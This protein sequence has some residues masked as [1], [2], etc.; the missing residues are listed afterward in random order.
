MSSLFELTYGFDFAALYVAN[1]GVAKPG[2]ELFR[3]KGYGWVRLRLF[4]SPDRLPNDLAYNW[5][6]AECPEGDG[7]FP[8]TPAGQRRF[9]EEVTRLVRATP[10]GRGKGVFR[11]K[12]AV[13]PGPIYSRGLFNDEGE[14]L[15]A[16][17]VF[18]HPSVT[19]R[20]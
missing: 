17:E 6:K 12:P 2:L 9:L 3:E 7:P 15:P 4:H 5:R 13:A 11:W 8:E 18:R 16:L 14:A 19:Q 10:D 20:P 1:S